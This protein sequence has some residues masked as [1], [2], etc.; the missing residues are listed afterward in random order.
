M[1]IP[2]N[3]NVLIGQMVVSKFDTKGIIQDFSTVTRRPIVLWNGN[4]RSMLVN[5]DDI[6]LS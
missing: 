2:T 4:S 5:W 1:K 6:E 3:I